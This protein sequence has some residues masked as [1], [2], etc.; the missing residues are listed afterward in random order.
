[1]LVTV[2]TSV[3]LA[4]TSPADVG[5]TKEVRSSTDGVF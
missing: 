3:E 2:V 1:M 4:S 5:L